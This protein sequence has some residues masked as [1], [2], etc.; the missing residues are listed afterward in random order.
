MTET[1]IFNQVSRLQALGIETHIACHRS[2][3]LDIFGVENVHCQADESPLR[4]RWRRELIRFHIRK[5]MY[6][7]YVYEVAKKNRSNII[8]SH[9]GNTAWRKHREAK[10]LK[11]KHIV[12][13]YGYDVN[14]L[15][16]DDPRWLERYD[17]LFQN[18]DRVLCEGSHMARC[19]VDLGCPADKVKVQHLGIDLEK[20]AFQP[21]QWKPGETLKVLISASFRE[22][23]GIPDAIRAL[24]IV[25][26]TTDIELTI[27][28]DASKDKAS[29][30]EKLE[31][32][33]A[34]DSCDHLNAINLLGYVTHDKLIQTASENHVFLQP[35]VT[36]SSGDT[37]GGAPV[38]IIEMLAS[39]MPVVATTHCDIPEV[40]GPSFQ[41]FL[42]PEHDIEKLA[43]CI[44]TLISRPDSWEELLM[45]ARHYIEDEYDR[46]KQA[47]K[48]I[49]HYDEILN[50]DEK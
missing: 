40:V 22:K 15:P 31:I 3:N 11:A 47:L 49:A 13:F 33:A 48:L 9:F 41:Q 29:Q 23:K 1:W 50:R 4:W 6:D 43:S 45:T 12:T 34:I 36:A 17:E 7:N 30:D 32:L 20:I 39:G 46:N 27:I 38:S 18:V 5:S 16:Q 14:R 28:G 37:E 10:R 26:E 2:E 21:R 44:S 24:D 8:H 19:I 25:A 42:A 35:S